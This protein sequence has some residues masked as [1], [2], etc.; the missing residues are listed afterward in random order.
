[1]GGK[2][3][4]SGRGSQGYQDRGKYWRGSY[5][6]WSP[7]HG[8]EKSLFP[9]YDHQRHQR[10]H[11]AGQDGRE[12]GGPKGGAPS[13]V[14]MI[15]T[16]LNATRKAEMR[17]TTLERNLKDKKAQWVQYQ[18]ELKEA[19]IKE[20][21]RYER[22]VARMQEELE[23]AMKMQDAA[24]EELRGVHH[25]AVHGSVPVRQE[26]DHGD[27]WEAMMAEWRSS[28]AAGTPE[29][30]LRRA[31]AAGGGMPSMVPQTLP[32]FGPPPGFGVGPMM[33]MPSN[34][35]VPMDTPAW[36][37]ICGQCP[38][39]S[40]FAVART[41]PPF[42]LLPQDQ[43][44]ASVAPG[45]ALRRW[46]C[47]HSGG[48]SPQRCSRCVG[49]ETCREESDGAFWWATRGCSCGAS[50]TD[51]PIQEPSA[52]NRVYQRRRADR[53]AACRCQAGR[54]LT[55]SEAAS[56]TEGRSGCGLDS[57]GR[58]R[59]WGNWGGSSYFSVLNPLGQCP[60]IGEVVPLS[61]DARTLGSEGQR[62]F[63]KKGTVV[64][65]CHPSGLGCQEPFGTYWLS[66]CHG[67][68][69][70]V[71][72]GRHQAYR[73]SHLFVPF[74][75]CYASPS[76]YHDFLPHVHG[77]PDKRPLFLANFGCPQLELRN[78]GWQCEEVSSAPKKRIGGSGTLAE[79]SAGRKG[80]EAESGDAAW[81]EMVVWGEFQ[82]A[83]LWV[84]W[85]G[86]I[87]L[88]Q[89]RW[90]LGRVKFLRWAPGRLCCTSVSQRGGTDFLV[91]ANF[92]RP[93]SSPL[94][95][96]TNPRHH[97]RRFS[98]S[99]G[100]SWFARVC[101]YALV[102]LQIP[103]C[104][105]AVPGG[106]PV[107]EVLTTLAS[108]HMGVSLPPAGLQASTDDNTDAMAPDELMSEAGA[109]HDEDLPVHVVIPHYQP[110]YGETQVTRNEMPDALLLRVRHM[111]PG[112]P[113]ASLDCLSPV[114]PVPQ[115]G[116]TFVAYSSVLDALDQAAVWV[117][118]KACGGEQFAAVLPARLAQE[119]W[120]AYILPLLH[121]VEDFD[122]FIGMEDA[123]HDNTEPLLLQHGA[124]IVVGPRGF[125]RPPVWRYETFMHL[126]E[127]WRVSVGA[128][129]V[130]DKP[131]FCLLMEDDRWVLRK[132]EFRHMSLHEAAAAC[133]G[134]Q[135]EETTL[136][137]AHR[138]PVEDLCVQG[139]HCCALAAIL[140]K[141]PPLPVPPARRH[142]QD[143]F[144]FLDS[145]P[146]GI[147]PTFAYQEGDTWELEDLLRVAGIVLPPGYD[148]F[149]SGGVLNGTQ[150]VVHNGDTIRFSPVSLGSENGGGGDESSDSSL[151]SINDDEVDD[152]PDP[153]A[154]VLAPRHHRQPERPRSRS[155][156]R[157][158]YAGC[159]VVAPEA[160]R[161]APAFMCDQ[162]CDEEDHSSGQPDDTPVG[163]SPEVDEEVD[164]FRSPMPGTPKASPSAEPNIAYNF[165]A[166]SVPQEMK[167]CSF[168]VLTPMFCNLLQMV[169][170]PFP[171]VSAIA[172][173]CLCQALRDSGGQAVSQGFYEA[174]P[175]V[176]QLDSERGSVVMCPVW[177]E[178]AG[179]QVV[180]L[181]MRALDGPL[182][183][184]IVDARMNY[185]DVQQ[186]AARHRLGEWHCFAFGHSTPLLPNMHFLAVK[187][188]VIKY[189]RKGDVP[190][191]A[192]RFVDRLDRPNMWADGCAPLTRA[193]H[194]PVLI[195]QEHG[196]TA[197]D[198]G[199]FPGQDLRTVA[200]N[201]LWRAPNEV[202]F[203]RPSA[204]GLV[205]LALHGVPYIGVISPY[206]ARGGLG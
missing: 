43:A 30:V 102:W 177:T 160:S 14:H 113:L 64:S 7:Q 2:T 128:P 23:G 135:E 181:D 74:C 24:R 20:S 22:D 59:S 93:H 42:D 41:T 126:P 108:A 34:P 119:H 120:R 104:V 97:R 96:N 178:A 8:K 134:L 111:F 73:I 82:A 133:V 38:S 46:S 89:V 150:V 85:C 165:R 56:P 149:V 145:R 123:P 19:W 55:R 167:E 50:P 132:R 153:P 201:L 35:P 13:Y 137:V 105:W 18:E 204:Q 1:M 9:A 199:R 15:Q 67:F 100:I 186:E 84:L 110:L 52:G 138:P 90:L 191:W 129:T 94:Q 172:M 11:G 21:Q 205:D 203:V 187:A 28:C 3:W 152:G 91:V 107:A 37:A 142:R 63:F 106:S 193:E 49:W 29:E 57:L 5:R 130:R 195:L 192:G 87:L 200:A 183:A 159:A 118:L 65:S 114:V 184:V 78:R 26:E 127:L 103:R 10:D 125:P 51:R 158:G 86:L 139:E 194:G 121:G 148:V 131:A 68:S 168:L 202:L 185:W 173:R 48:R 77:R 174:V 117:D 60:A 112:E 147:R 61:G 40:V 197:F 95:W 101:L 98:S 169:T 27:T 17:V 16:S 33:G 31:M 47:G 32:H 53:G 166:S 143:V 122:C 144:V 25:A 180:V 58:P 4:Q 115:Q 80:Y 141:P 75:E 81:S 146:F 196:A 170:L 162:A 72:C 171:C 154:S 140:D 157:F 175:V 206:A 151:L 124:L 155:P 109:W 99:K 62:V 36:G 54:H 179:K 136:A 71:G 83:S 39:G 88:A 188:G 70:A 45:H 198:E 156:R 76:I 164:P 6:A 163:R 182:Y 12:H 176:P 92:G 189:V 44:R 66:L 116:A 161:S 190:D 79:D 69:L